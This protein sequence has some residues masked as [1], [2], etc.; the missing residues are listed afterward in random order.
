LVLEFGL[1]ELVLGADE[2]RILVLAAMV[3]AGPSV[4][5]ALLG[6]LLLDVE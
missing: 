1:E 2:G 5:V 3:V 4:Y 6:R